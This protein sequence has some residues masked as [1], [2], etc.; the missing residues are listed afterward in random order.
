ME[1]KNRWKEGTR[2]KGKKEGKEKS[3]HLSNR[4][5]KLNYFGSKLS[6]S[7]GKGNSLY[8]SSY[9]QYYLRN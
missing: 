6:L 7:I 5:K 8:Y 1:R 9:I 2:N 4:R 3:N